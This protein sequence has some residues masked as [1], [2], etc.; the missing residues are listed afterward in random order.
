MQ[1]ALWSRRPTKR[2]SVPATQA[3]EAPGAW[4]G[5]AGQAYATHSPPEPLTPQWHDIERYQHHQPHPAPSS[6]Q[7]PSQQAPQLL[8]PPLQGQAQMLFEPTA[9]VMRHDGMGQGVAQRTQ[10]PGFGTAAEAMSA[11]GQVCLLLMLGS[12]GRI[13]W[14]VVHFPECGVCSASSVHSTV[15]CLVMYPSRLMGCCHRTT[16]SAA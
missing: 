16:G 12:T 6:F 10:F 1:A 4:T 5:S 7:Q 9:A 3:A 15:I 8:P 13:P 2:R 14:G 11:T